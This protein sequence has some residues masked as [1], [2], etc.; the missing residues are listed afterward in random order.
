MDGEESDT[1]DDSA[2]D[3]SLDANCESERDVSDHY[4]ESDYDDEDSC[5]EEEA[6]QQI[7]HTIIYRHPPPS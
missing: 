4:M 3:D 7:Q 1:H 2:T 5:S 6:V